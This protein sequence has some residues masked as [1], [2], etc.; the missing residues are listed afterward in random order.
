MIT[1]LHFRPSTFRR[2]SR[3]LSL[4]ELALSI[5]VGG[6]VLAVAVNSLSPVQNYNSQHQVAADVVMVVNNVRSYYN[7]QPGM[8]NSPFTTLTAQLITNQAIPPFMQ[9][10][11]GVCPSLAVCADG[12][13]GGGNPI[14]N[15]GTFR[16]CPWLMGTSTACSG[17]AIATSLNFL[18]MFAIEVTNLAQSDCA[19]TVGD[20]SAPSGGPTGLL[21]VV[22]NGH[23][24]VAA[25]DPIQP[26][27]SAGRAFCNTTT[28]NI[29]DFVY[30]LTPPAS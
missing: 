30:R 11:G 17:A 23:S 6:A 29:V 15:A 7:G 24:L 2:N 9:R 26:V 21:D 28:S 14:N 22:I 27:A 5:G 4:M 25:G 12:P 10:P 13:W 1:L 19:V 20:V 3:A 8:P 18:T 16:V